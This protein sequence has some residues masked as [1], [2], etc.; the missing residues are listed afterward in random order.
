M[1]YFIDTGSVPDFKL[2]NC[3]FMVILQK[4]TD[5]ITD[6]EIFQRGDRSEVMYSYL[7]WCILVRSQQQLE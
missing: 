1:S 4:E 2:F 6:S 5:K 3:Y 7:N